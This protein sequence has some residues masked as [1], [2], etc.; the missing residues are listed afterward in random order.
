MTR[1]SAK[2]VI[3]TVVLLLDVDVVVVV[4]EETVVLVL[5][6]D[7]DEVVVRQVQSGS[8]LNAAN[9]R[10]HDW[11]LLIDAALSAAPHSMHLRDFWF[12]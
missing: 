8:R 4:E 10:C 3:L 9:L 6:D 12:H 2:N 7:D 1:R 5:L 11:A